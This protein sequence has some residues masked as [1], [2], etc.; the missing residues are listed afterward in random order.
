MKEDRTLKHSLNWSSGAAGIELQ[1][2]ERCGKSHELSQN[3]IKVKDGSCLQT[4]QRNDHDGE[5]EQGPDRNSECGEYSA[6]SCLMTYAEEKDR[7]T[8]GG[9]DSNEF[10]HESSK[11]VGK[12][13]S[14]PGITWFKSVL[15]LVGLT[16]AWQSSKVRGYPVGVNTAG[17]PKANNS[18]VHTE[19]NFF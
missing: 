17:N 13:V 9:D 2:A 10:S 14:V 5:S 6:V 19:F 3:L 4:H 16:A 7:R 11:C 1:I 8:I 12:D 18:S 15:K